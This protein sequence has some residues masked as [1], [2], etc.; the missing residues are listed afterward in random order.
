MGGTSCVFLVGGIGGWAAATNLSGAVVASGTFVVDSYVKKIQHLTGG[1]ISEILIKE[2]QKIAA[3]DVLVRLD[4]TQARANLGIVTKRLDELTA[5]LARLEAERD[6][7]DQIAFPGTLLSRLDNTD[8]AAAVQSER[9]L[10]E[11]RK[12]DR[13]GKKSQLR[14]RIKQFAHEID[15]L[16]SRETAFDRGLSVLDAE[17]A[18]LQVLRAKGIVSVLR[19]NDLEREAATLGGDRGEAMAGQAQAAG[20]ISEARLQ[21]LQIDSDLKTEVS[22]ELREVQGQIGEYIERKIAAEDQLKR[23]DIIAPQAGIVHQLA[24]HTVGGVISPGD[25]I[26]SIVPDSG[27]LALDAQIAPRDI[28]QIE[29]GQKAVLRLSAFNQ[30]TTPEL[31][32]T[33]VRIAADL[34][35]NERSG[36]SYYQVRFVVAPEELARLDGLI[37]LPGMPVEAFIKTHERSAFSYFVKPLSDQISRAFRED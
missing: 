11:F 5:R 27:G 9:R 14:E 28:D 35:T 21:I 16:K 13:A 20:R 17:I 18:S 15:G 34:T 37:V 29:L 31:N 36:S 10:F 3:G 32:G 7:E 1:V 6:D 4:A 22:A 19:L 2:G 24:F 23:I 12:E 8:I 25:V 26:M 30:R 33:V